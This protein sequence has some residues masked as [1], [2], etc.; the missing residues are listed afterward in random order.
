MYYSIRVRTGV[1]LVCVSGCLH[2]EYRAGGI[3]RRE[4]RLIDKDPSYFIPNISGPS[5]K[6]QLVARVER[7]DGRIVVIIDDVTYREPIQ[8]RSSTTY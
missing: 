7:I 1:S 6:L 8:E 4:V 3:Q 5:W 2:Y